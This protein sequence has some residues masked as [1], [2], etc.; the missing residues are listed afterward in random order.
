[1]ELFQ[2][3]IH[4]FIEEHKNEAS[5]EVEY[6]VNGASGCKDAL[7][8]DLD[9]AADVFS[10]PDD[11]LLT[12][13]A[14]GVLE[15]V[16]NGSAIA[17]RNLEGAVEAASVNGTVYAYPITADNGYFLYYDKKYLTENDVQTLDRILE[18]CEK[19]KRN[20]LWIGQAAGTCILFWQYRAAGRF[21]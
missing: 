2:E 21:K 20:L 12:L 19:Q 16:A 1:M 18:V 3:M 13:V 4:T 11:Q 6:E 5:I 10:I 15:P 9:N 17:E 7:L 8:A 14:A